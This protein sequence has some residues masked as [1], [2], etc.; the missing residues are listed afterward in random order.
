MNR[1]NNQTNMRESERGP[2]QKTDSTRSNLSSN[3]RYQ[4]AQKSNNNKPQLRG[5]IEELKNNVYFLGGFKQ[6]D[7]YDTVTRNIY[8][9]MQ[10]TMDIGD[11]VVTALRQK[12]EIDFDEMIRD[13]PI[14]KEMATEN[15]KLAGIRRVQKIID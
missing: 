15:Q 13:L 1:P 14:V 4:R 10:C 12:G 7:N 6:N 8:M 2:N 11:D 3:N 5:A 9:Y